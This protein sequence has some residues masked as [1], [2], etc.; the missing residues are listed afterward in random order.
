MK[1]YTKKTKER[2]YRDIARNLSFG[3]N[4]EIAPIPDTWKSLLNE[5]FD[6]LKH[7][8]YEIASI[9]DNFRYRYN[10]PFWRADERRQAEAD[11]CVSRRVF[12]YKDIKYSFSFSLR[13][14]C[15]WNYMDG[16]Y[17][18]NNEQTNFTA[19]KNL[20]KKMDELIQF[21]DVMTDEDRE[22]VKKILYP[23]CY[24]ECGV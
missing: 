6:N 4:S 2:F 10:K 21:V 22:E 15:N 24:K 20:P 19:I 23:M 5:R 14:S 17:F 11:N 16:F 1:K 18:K 12:Y 8:I 13:C 9:M 3:S 7:S